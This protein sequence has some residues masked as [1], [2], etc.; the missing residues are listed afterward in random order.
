[1]N[2]EL[3]DYF[4]ENHGL[5]LL[6]SEVSDIEIAVNAALD[7][8]V[9]RLVGRVT[10]L[11]NTVGLLKKR[12]A[13]LQSG[14]R[15][16]AEGAERN[17]LRGFW[18]P[19]GAALPDDDTTVLICNAGWNGD[20]VTLGYMDDGD[21]RDVDGICFANGKNGPA[22]AATPTHWMELPAAWGECGKL[23]LGNERESCDK[24]VAE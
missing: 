11:E 20:P 22:R 3:F 17:G 19:V 7:G 2:Q 5:T 15:G 24:E 13:E 18:V 12:N 1:M 4:A 23:E 14:S 21:W 10:E 9:R 16:D 6:E 8:K